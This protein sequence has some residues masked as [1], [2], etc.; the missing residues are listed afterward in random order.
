MIG[1]MSVPLRADE[2][3]IGSG[4]SSNHELPCYTTYSYSLTQQIYTAQELGGN[5]GAIKSVAFYNNGTTQTRNIDIY[6]VSTEKASFSSKSDW[7][8]VATNNKVFSGQVTLTKNAWTA[9][10]FDTYFAYDGT[11]NIAIM[12][13][14]RSMVRVKQT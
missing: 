4:T 9:I 2:V 7:I 5:E 13:G 11:S 3:T 14:S 12:V 8:P 10:T 6:I 1:L